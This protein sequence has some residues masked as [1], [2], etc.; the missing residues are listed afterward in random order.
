M[1]EHGILA[2][3]KGLELV[4]KRLNN[5]T[6]N[7]RTQ[8]PLPTVK[9]G[10]C[11]YQISSLVDYTRYGIS[12]DRVTWRPLGAKGFDSFSLNYCR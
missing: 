4:P 9:A 8:P 12:G 2:L 5:D 10:Y 11:L 7:P 6:V 3:C 1:S